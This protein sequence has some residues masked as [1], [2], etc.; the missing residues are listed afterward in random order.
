MVAFGA[1]DCAL[2]TLLMLSFILMTSA[3]YENYTF[4]NFP[5]EELMPLTTAYGLALDHYAAERWTES[6]EYLELS[7]RLR[8]LLRDSVR[9]C[10]LLCD[11]SKHEELNFTGDK[12]LNIQ[13][14]FMMRATCQKKCRA[15]FP[16]LQLPPPG[17]EILQEFSRRSPYKYLHFAHSKVRNLIILSFFKF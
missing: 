10:A 12:D 17:R 1:K 7:L 9:Y 8:R 15:K 13:W 4:R 11:N 5:T 3:Q 2:V 16:F 6:I 14:H